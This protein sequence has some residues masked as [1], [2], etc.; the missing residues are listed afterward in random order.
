[1]ARTHLNAAMDRLNQ[2]GV[3]VCEVHPDAHAQGIAID[4]AVA[5]LSQPQLGNASTATSQTTVIPLATTAL[6]AQLHTRG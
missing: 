6:T 5:T 3:N 2:P 1:M 4:Q